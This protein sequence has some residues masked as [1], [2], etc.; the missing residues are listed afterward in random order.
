MSQPATKTHASWTSRWTFI[1]A[2]TGSAVGL[3]NIWKF[4]YITGEN[5]GGAFVLVYLL[6]I[7]IV[8]VPVLMAEILMG[9][10]GRS[11][12]INSMVAL[13]RAS[14]TSK[15]WAFIGIWGTIAGLMIMCFYSVVAGW[16]LDYLVESAKGTF[17]GMAPEQV[18]AHFEAGLLANKPLQ[19]LWHTVFTLLTIGVVAAGVT[20]GLGTA[21]E[22][23]M[24][25]LFLL[26]LILLGYSITNGDFYRAAHFL[27]TPDFSKLTG[28]SVL[29]AMGQSFFTL[30]IGMG[31]MMA[32]GSYMPANTSITQTAF[33]VVFFDT[34]VALMAG[35]AIFPLVFANGIEPGQG[36]GL[37]FVSLP[38]AFGN[39]Q[40]GVFFG[41][42]FFILLTLAAWTSSISLI[43]PAAAWIDENFRISRAAA[44][45]LIG[46]L[47]WVGGAA[48]IYI[49]GL[50]DQMDHI[51]SNIMLPLGGLMIA[52]FVGWFMKR[53]L[54]KNQLGELGYYTF[55]T[56]YA[57]LRVFT[58]IGV[59]AVFLY[60]LGI[61]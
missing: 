15:A 5:G 53:K 59:L 49:D 55:N 61:L 40:G 42:L 47:V 41:S 26:L 43:E 33:A 16:V 1:M 19:L 22:I 51:A 27:F 9:R 39:M 35:L 57:V 10:E 38:I 34:L 56:W 25:M 44:T 45:G 2:A 4:P 48:C 6:C 58:P 18:A 21:V 30:S 24:P 14:D 37:I 13:A 28:E 50:F 23:M 8:G 11:S 54:V 7:A 36:P 20:R 29:V 60:K 17:V 32:Y 46:F 3:G 31:A 12:P 52:I